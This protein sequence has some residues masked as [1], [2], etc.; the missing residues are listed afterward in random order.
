MAPTDVPRGTV[1]LVDAPEEERAG[2]VCQQRDPAREGRDVVEV[3]IPGG[4]E[5]ARELLGPRSHGRQRLRARSRYSCSPATSGSE[6]GRSGAHHAR[7][8][9][10][11]RAQTGA[12]KN[13]RT[14]R[15]YYSIF[16]RSKQPSTWFFAFSVR[17]DFEPLTKGL[18]RASPHYRFPRLRNARPGSLKRLRRCNRALSGTGSPGAAAR[19]ALRR[20]RPRVRTRVRTAACT[21]FGRRGSTSPAGTTDSVSSVHPVVGTIAWHA[22]QPDRL[23]L[24]FG[25]P[26]A[27]CRARPQRVLGDVHLS[28]ASQRR[29]R[30][31]SSVGVP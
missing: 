31:V 29:R 11:I 14:S 6:D 22:Q 27:A 28:S 9:A 19:L 16:T 3:G 8:D 5:V 13:P 30:G 2:A 17:P 25:S 15:G 4:D 12:R 23:R 1:L 18:Y 10:Q 7:L 20:D 26:A 21:D 24:S